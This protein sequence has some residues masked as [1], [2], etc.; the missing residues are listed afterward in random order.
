MA[1][2][3]TD[4]ITVKTSRNSAKMGV[5]FDSGLLQTISKMIPFSKI[6]MLIK[7]RMMFLESNIPSKPVKPSKAETKVKGLSNLASFS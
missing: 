3:I 1:S 5:S 7:M 6:S 4:K 2:A